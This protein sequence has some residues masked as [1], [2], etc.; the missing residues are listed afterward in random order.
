MD[1]DRRERE[2]RRERDRERRR[3]RGIGLGEREKRGE[4][5]KDTSKWSFRRWFLKALDTVGEKRRERER[6]EKR[7][8]VSI[9]CEHTHNCV[10]RFHNREGVL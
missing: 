9:R 2:G 8:R 5:V 3:Q 1:V 7:E 6:G 4:K 10:Q